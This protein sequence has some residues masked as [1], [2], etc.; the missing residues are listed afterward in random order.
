MNYSQ[1]MLMQLILHPLF[2]YVCVNIWKYS[3]LIWCFWH[4]NIKLFCT[5]TILL[6]YSKQIFVFCWNR[7][8]PQFSLQDLL[9]LYILYIA[10]KCNTNTFRVFLFTFAIN[11]NHIFTFKLLIKLSKWQSSICGILDHY[12][13][14]SSWKK[15]IKVNKCD[16]KFR[17]KKFF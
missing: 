17:I 4:K 13:K 9:L 15:K 8:T 1:C 5:W 6:L 2:S 16:S 10:I 7:N 11:S 12:F 14:S 3:R